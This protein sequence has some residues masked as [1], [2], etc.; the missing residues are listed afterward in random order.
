[1]T[2]GTCWAIGTKQNENHTNYLA[3]LNAVNQWYEDASCREK[4]SQI[5]KEDPDT[6]TASGEDVAIPLTT[7]RGDIES[8]EHSGIPGLPPKKSND[9]TRPT[10]V[11]QSQYT[12]HPS[13]GGDGR[14]DIRE[15]PQCREN[16]ARSG[17][18]EPWEDMHALP[19][20][21]FSA[22]SGAKLSKSRAHRADRQQGN[23][24]RHVHKYF[25]HTTKRCTV[26]NYALS[27]YEAQSRGTV[28]ARPWI[29]SEVKC[30]FNPEM[31]ISTST[32]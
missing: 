21:L 31:P 26:F 11:H 29:W 3:A 17:D 7:F 13:D 28:L 22:F 23:L 2:L 9:A 24:L 32:G 25:R 18:I 30:V 16:G 19:A 4:I 14:K 1:M 6:L 20:A 5:F 8:W 15:L 27:L 10:P 12:H